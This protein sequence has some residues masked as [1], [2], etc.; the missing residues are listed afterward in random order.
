M[1]SH[2]S[3]LYRSDK[4]VTLHKLERMVGLRSTLHAKSCQKVPIKK[5]LWDH[6]I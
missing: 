4:A 1:Y 2:I 6:C 3:P 5:K